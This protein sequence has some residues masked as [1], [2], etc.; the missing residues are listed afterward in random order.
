MK[1]ICEKVTVLAPARLHMGFIDLSG[2]LGRDFGSIGI[3]LNEIHTR[4]TVTGG[5]TLRVSGPGAERA[6][7]YTRKLCQAMHTPETLQV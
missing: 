3:A 4:L 2:A 5:D 6:R 1:A 7:K